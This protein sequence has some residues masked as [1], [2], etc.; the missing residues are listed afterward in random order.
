MHVEREHLP[1]LK[2]FLQGFID[3]YDA[4]ESSEG[5]FC[6]SSDVAH[7]RAGICGNKHNAQEGRPQADAGAQRE[8]GESVFTGEREEHMFYHFKKHQLLGLIC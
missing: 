5:L 4:D 1:Q 2:E 7:Q 8:V 3:E 6:E